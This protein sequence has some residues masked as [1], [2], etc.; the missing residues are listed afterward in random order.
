[1]IV[2]LIEEELEPDARERL[3]SDSC[4]PRADEDRGGG[5]SEPDC[6]QAIIA[7]DRP[8]ILERDFYVHRQIDPLPQSVEVVYTRGRGGF[9]LPP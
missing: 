3:G 2:Q 4:L 5:A 1:M 7:A 8:V 9:D 6:L